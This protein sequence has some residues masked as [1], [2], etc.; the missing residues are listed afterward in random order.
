MRVTGT[1]NELEPISPIATRWTFDSE[2]GKQEE[3]NHAI[4][5]SIIYA[6]LPE[7]QDEKDNSPAKGSLAPGTY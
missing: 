1:R 6:T 2:T 4:F 5:A 3:K 7:P